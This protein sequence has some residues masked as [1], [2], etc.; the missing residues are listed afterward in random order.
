MS[1][2]LLDLLPRT[3]LKV[4][5]SFLGSSSRQENL[6]LKFDICFF[7]DLMRGVGSWPLTK[8]A[9]PMP[10]KR[11]LPVLSPTRVRFLP[12]SFAWI[13]H[14]LRSSRLLQRMSPE[15]IGLYLFLSLAADAQGLSCWRLDRIEREFSSF[16]TACLRRARDGLI[17]LDLLA[18]Q[19]WHPH[20][21]DGCY[22][23]PAL[24]QVVPP[25]RFDGPVTLRSVLPPFPE[26]RR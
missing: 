15:E 23:L 3:H 1:L 24:P 12:R 11:P 16:D 21:L 13:D 4:E 26:V 18:F 20:A 7:E 14:R 17:G 8:G 25:N 19:P 9:I 6:F 5:S 2:L 10:T 22:Q